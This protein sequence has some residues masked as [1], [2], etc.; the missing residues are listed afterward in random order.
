M[1]YPVVN[2]KEARI[3]WKAWS[4]SSDPTAP[5]E[6]PPPEKSEYGDSHDWHQIVTSTLGKLHELYDKVESNSEKMST[7]RFEAQACTVIHD[8]L[9]EDEALADSGFWIWVATGP[10]LDLVIRRYPIKERE[11]KPSKIPGRDNFTSS[12]ARETFFYRMWVR[13]HLAH[14]K[15]R[16][17]PYQLARA[18]DVDFWR[19]HVFRQMASEA[20]PMLA[21]FIEFQYP[22]GSEGSKRLKQEEVRKLVKYIKRASANIVI[23]TLNKAEARSMIERQWAKIET[24]KET[25]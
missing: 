16:T 15:N 25:K 21:A 24:Q 14:D 10:G 17:D 18:G 1:P 4:D 7:D 2:D 22:N 8:E 12:N 9:P 20:K 5:P 23:E 6:S 13:A 19:S 3:W 11:G